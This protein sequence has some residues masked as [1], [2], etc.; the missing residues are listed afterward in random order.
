LSLAPSVQADPLV[1]ANVGALQNHNT[2]TIDLFSNPGATLFGQQMTFRV[3][4]MGILPAGGSDTL[5]ITYQAMGGPLVTQNYQ[6]PLFGS[7]YPPFTHLFTI[8][9]TGAVPGGRPVT[10][11][12]DLL[13][14]SPDFIIPTGPGAGQ[15]VDSYSFTFNVAQPVPEPATIIIF[16]SGLTGLAIRVRRGCRIRSDKS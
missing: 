6:L 14:S 9:F 4:I 16:S 11:T 15:G 2:T 5:R 12:V 7:V 8:P 10:L 1:F 3:D 13:G